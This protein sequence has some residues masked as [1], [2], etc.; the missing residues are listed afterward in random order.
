LLSSLYP[1]QYQLPPTPS[2]AGPASPSRNR[3]WLWFLLLAVL[4][5]GAFGGYKLRDRSQAQAAARQGQSAAP[6]VP[7]AMAPVEKRDVPVYLQGLGSVTAFNTVTV[8]TRIDGQLLQVDF[9]EGQ[10]E[11]AGDVMAQIDPRPYQVALDQAQGQL[12][13]DQAQLTVARLDL[14][15]YEKLWQEGV[16][17]QQQYDTQKAAVA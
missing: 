2:R 10:F 5:G 8:R 9:R 7:V 13:R 17:S 12:A 11:H 1:A 3:L 14:A 15:R 6:G 16:F 4:L